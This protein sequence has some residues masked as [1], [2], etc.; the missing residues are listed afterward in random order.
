[1]FKRKRKLALILTL[2][3][4]F[5]ALGS[6]GVEA[7][8]PGNLIPNGSFELLSGGNIT[9]WTRTGGNI[10]TDENAY[11]GNTYLNLPA[12]ASSR[13]QITIPIKE[14]TSYLL[15]L[16]YKASLQNA[17]GVDLE[18][19]RD[20]QY[21]YSGYMKSNNLGGVATMDGAG[22][23]FGSVQDVASLTW[24]KAEI[25][26]TTPVYTNELFV[27]I[28][29]ISTNTDANLC[30]DNVVLKEI[31]GDPNLVPNGSFEYFTDKENGVSAPILWSADTASTKTKISVFTDT[32]GTILP[33]GES[34]LIINTNGEAQDIDFTGSIFLM[35]GNYK[36]TFKHRVSE[37]GEPLST[38]LKYGPTMRLYGHPDQNGYI[39]KQSPKKANTWY[40]H[41]MYFTVPTGQAAKGISL[42]WYLGRSANTTGIHYYDDIVLTQDKTGIDFGTEY[43]YETTGVWEMGRV[44]PT[45]QIS[46]TS[47]AQEINVRAHYVPESVSDEGYTLISCVYAYDETANTKKLHTIEI[48]NSDPA[49]NGKISTLVD[50]ITVPKAEEGIS[51][52]VEAFL[53]D[54]VSGLMPVHNSATLV[55]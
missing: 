30:V 51:Y 13:V 2:A 37:T 5:A 23:Q 20:G 34:C 15:S 1:M 10:M 26:F 50:T 31:K 24:K 40:E 17:G 11:D 33:K 54:S 52:K 38:Y 27:K 19:K 29:G 36:L 35:E 8:A 9:E 45:P 46:N 12:G 3:M 21:V 49:M 16:W 47:A 4:V 48:A 6:F 25:P 53:W 44:I 22:A 18:F 55:E 43:L 32:E 14:N 7:S 42:I 39:Y 41:T 28:K